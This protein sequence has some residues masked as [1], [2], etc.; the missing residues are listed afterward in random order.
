MLGSKSN[1]C[2]MGSGKANLKSD[3]DSLLD[4][5]YKRKRA[6]SALFQ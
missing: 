2:G 4:G 5:S 6:G 3:L 1:F